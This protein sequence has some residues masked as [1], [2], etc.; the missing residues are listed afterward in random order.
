MARA[1]AS[2]GEANRGRALH[3]LPNGSI[4]S[5]RRG[6]PKGERRRFRSQQRLEREALAVGHF[7]GTIPR[8]LAVQ[9]AAS[10]LAFLE[11]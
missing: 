11:G 1:N 5:A 3:A 4:F 9:R 10:E 6:R 7:H 2:G 8:R